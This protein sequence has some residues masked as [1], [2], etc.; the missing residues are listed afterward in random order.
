[1]PIGDEGLDVEMM[2]GLVEGKDYEV[3]SPEFDTKCRVSTSMPTDRLFY[4]EMAKELYMAKLI[5]EN[6]FWY[7]V[8]KGKFPPGKKKSYGR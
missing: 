6:I 8:D 2:G 4:M 1:M 7:V 5:D 3:Y